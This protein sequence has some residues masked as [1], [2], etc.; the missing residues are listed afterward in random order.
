MIS[1]RHLASIQIAWSEAIHTASNPSLFFHVIHSGNLLASIT[2]TSSFPAIA[3]NMSGVSQSLFLLIMPPFASSCP[4]SIRNSAIPVNPH[5]AA[6]CSEVLL[7]SSQSGFL[8]YEG[9]LRMMRFTRGRS[10]RRMARRRRRDTS[11]LEKGL[12]VIER[13]RNC[14]ARRSDL[15]FD[16]KDA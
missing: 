7:R 13:R 16:G 2:P 1:N 4:C 15:H 8:R 10:L 14:I 6:R 5:R 12:V 3:A 9:L 11:I